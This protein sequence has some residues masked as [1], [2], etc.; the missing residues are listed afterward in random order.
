MRKTYADM[1]SNWEF[2]EAAEDRRGLMRGM[3]Y[4]RRRTQASL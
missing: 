3:G 4:N 2:G 1:R